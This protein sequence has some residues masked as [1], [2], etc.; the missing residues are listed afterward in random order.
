MK[1]LMIVVFLFVI[2][3]SYADVI[4]EENFAGYLHATGIVNDGGSVQ[5]NGD[6]PVDKW[7]VSIHSTSD[8]EHFYT[9]YN[10][11]TTVYSLQAKYSGTGYYEFITEGIDISDYYMVHCT[12]YFEHSPETSTLDSD[13]YVK[14]YYSLNGGASYTSFQGGNG[15]ITGIIDET[16]DRAEQTSL[17]GDT[18]L[19]KMEIRANG[20]TEYY[21]I[22]KISVVG[23]RTE[24]T[25]HVTDLSGEEILEFDQ[26][27]IAWKDTLTSETSADGYLIKASAGAITDP[28]DGVNPVFD[29]DLSDGIAEISVSS[30]VASGEYTCYFTKYQGNSTYNFKVYSYTNSS[31][32]G[33]IYKTCAVV[34]S[35][36]VSTNPDPVNPGAIDL[37]INEISGDDVMPNPMDGYIELYNRK[38]WEIDL[39]N[40]VIRYYDNGASSPTATL[41]LSGKVMPHSFVLIVQDFGTFTMSYPEA[42]PSFEAPKDGDGNSLF[43]L[44]GGSDVIE[45]YLTAKAGT[46]DTFNDKS[47]PWT[48]DSSK[49]YER[50]SANDG[51]NQTSWDENGDGVPGEDDDPLPITLSSFTATEIQ[52]AA[53]LKWQTSSE[54]N[55]FGWNVYRNQTESLENAEKLTI[56]VIPGAGTSDTSHNYSYKDEN[57]PTLNQV[58][59]Y[60][61]ESIDYSGNTQFYGPKEV[62][63]QNNDDENTPPENIECTLYQNFPNPF[64]PSTMIKFMS[65]NSGYAT[66]KIYNI[67]GKLIKTIFN[68][69][70][71]PKKLYSVEWDGKNEQG[72]TVANGVYFYKLT[73]D[74]NKFTK[75]MLLLK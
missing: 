40:V 59:Y 68:N 30:G 34:P 7:Q 65:D 61:I 38:S 1:K 18:L 29:D 22:K 35:C 43:P 23:Y 26:I 64:N 48:W 45:V 52:H 44:D 60:W 4:W 71:I 21:N 42:S 56:S 73:T 69:S 5:N 15:T 33:Y 57:I 39:S 3:I 31:C 53:L 41:A 25:N 50:S 46:I 37:I 11:N 62:F 9:V 63:I 72:K 66:V 70:T 14:T 54:L 2:C 49:N 51:E 19:I 47:S 32:H 74:S 20:I 28:V 55:N 10:T 67:Q 6:Y 16:N 8:F 17:C 58:Y 75:K 12:V 13:D 36:S 24:P 27:E